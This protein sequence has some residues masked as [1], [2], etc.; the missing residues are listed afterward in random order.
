MENVNLIT[1]Q[2]P[3]SPIA[4]S[5]RTLRTNIQFSSFDKKLQSIVITSSGPGEGKTT[6]S[7]NL[8]VV[9]AQTGSKTILIDCDQRKPSVHK[10]FKLSNEVGLSDFL[11]GSVEFEE[12][13]RDSGVENLT[14]IT[15]G[16]RPPNPSE[17]LSS[18]KMRDFIEGLKE[19]YEYI[20][21]DS[22]PIVAVTDAQ[23]IASFADGSLL[24]TSSG[25]VE[26][27]AAMRSKEL[28]DKVNSKI[29]GVV[30][31]KLEVSEKGYYGYYYQYYYGNDG[32]HKSKKKKGNKTSEVAV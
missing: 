19:E 31:N 28:L 9:M 30:L 12:V 24:V 17:L 3:K 27:E 21:I 22:P 23:L 13:T 6:T 5:Y 15:S 10:S 8:A 2:D 29:L 11:V 20:I 32:A 26:R 7:C 1:I 4:E 25:E 14:L 18:K 16:T